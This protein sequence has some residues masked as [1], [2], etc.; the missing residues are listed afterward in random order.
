MVVEDLGEENDEVDTSQA[1]VN[2]QTFGMLSH[3]SIMDI[4]VGESH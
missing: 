4:S 3:S 2:H 1:K